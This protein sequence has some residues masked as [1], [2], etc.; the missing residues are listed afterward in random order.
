M[1]PTRPAALY[2]RARG[3]IGAGLPELALEDATLLLEIE[4]DDPIAHLIKT[5]ALI[6]LE[7]Y[8]EAEQSHVNFKR[9]AEAGTSADRAAR[10]CGG[11]AMY[12]K[13][14]E[15]FDKAGEVFDECLEKYPDHA[16]LRNWAT[17]F[18]TETNEPA[19]AEALWRRAIDANPE[20][21]AP[22]VTL[23]KVLIS[24][25]RNA[26]AEKV[27]EEAAEL[28]DTGSAWQALASIYRRNGKTTEARK[29]LETALERA[30]RE[31][32]GLRFALADMLIEE[33]ELDRAQEIANSMKEASYRALLNGA[34]LL[35]RD[36][37]RAALAQLEAGLRL[38][39]N[40]ARARY[41]AGR[42]ATALGDDKRA[43]Q[44]YREAL[45]ISETETNAALEL[46]RLYYQEGQ[47][48]N[49]QQ[50]AGRHIANPPLEGSAAH[51][52]SARAAA[53]QGQ[54]E[55][56]KGILDALAGDP[57]FR[58]V[59]AAEYAQILSD[60]AGAAAA[61]AWI[62]QRGLD[63]RD[64]ANH[65]ALRALVSHLVAMG[66][67][68]EALKRVDAALAQH[69]DDAVDNELRARVLMQLDRRQEAESNIERAL[70]IDPGLAGAIEVLGHF[71]ALDGDLEGALREFDRA[72][73]ADP[74]NADYLYQA[75]TVTQRL[76]RED[77]TIVRLRGA[78]ERD[79]RHVAACNDLAWQ[80]AEREE[81]LDWA[82]V[83]ATRAAQTERSATT[84]DTLGW[85]LFK[86]GDTDAAI[87]SLQSALELEPN[88]SSTRYRLG[89]AL[90]K[91][92]QTAEAR[93]EIESA[94]AGGS[95]PERDAA[96]AELARLQGS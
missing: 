54:V 42:T 8:E 73:A 6:D 80:L 40:N 2:N 47:F 33:G 20:D 43:M 23:S 74:E 5:S 87:R 77:D 93:S 75:S 36:Q 59:A 37:P 60:T 69:P 22:R 19:K 94:L 90:A 26:E 63:L 56:A 66:S 91:S 61:V 79:P 11:L 21:M 1:D 16:L 57:R 3:R 41:I 78:V 76:G 13:G 39:P 14:R 35:A 88:A 67:A 18:Y 95:F 49:A 85:V 30:R 38:W 28:F 29:T 31:P 53:A 12:Y 70:A 17:G 81:E 46:A 44:E 24:Q 9:V 4:P 89:L 65:V 32:E 7:R 50:F 10:A 45:R 96:R 25:G 51:V 15:E 71:A 82:L 64:P 68:R 52:I 34:I 48:S 84:L 83:F 92:G 86:K 55:A 72:A 27:L 58:A 62:E